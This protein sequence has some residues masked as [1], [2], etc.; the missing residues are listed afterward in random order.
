MLVYRHVSVLQQASL[1]PSF[2]LHHQLPEQWLL[3]KRQ[4][5]QGFSLHLYEPTNGLHLH[6][7]ALIAELCAPLGPLPPASPII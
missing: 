3:K 2:L 7:L 4:Q 5:R 6:E 1:P